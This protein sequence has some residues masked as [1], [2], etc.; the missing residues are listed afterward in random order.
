MTIST[1][2]SANQTVQIET[3]IQQLR[4]KNFDDGAIVRIDYEGKNVK[5]KNI[6]PPMEI[7]TLM[8]LSIAANPMQ[9]S[10]NETTSTT[11]DFI[12]PLSVGSSMLFD[13]D[14]YLTVTITG[15]D[16][17]TSA[18]LISV[19]SPFNYD[20]KGKKYPCSTYNRF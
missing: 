10:I 11:K 8:N 3:S 16:G 1:S 4:F 7:N 20:R 12:M 15:H 9:P 14:K 6:V 17:T 19:D 2:T 13:D 18:S 5:T